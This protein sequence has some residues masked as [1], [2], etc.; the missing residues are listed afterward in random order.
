MKK[1]KYILFKEWCDEHGVIMPKVEFPA[2]FGGDLIGAKCLDDIK[3]REALIFV[4]MNLLLTVNN[5]KK[6]E[7]LSKIIKENE[8]V[9]SDEDSDCD[10]FILVLYLFYETCLGT[11]SFWFPYIRSMPN[12]E[13]VGSW[14]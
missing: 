13:F 9:F 5:A 14:D 10:H 7:V 1:D 4:P 3:H 2:Y 11:E 12:V 8:E 6:H